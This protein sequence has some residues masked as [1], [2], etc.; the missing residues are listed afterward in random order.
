ME[1]WGAEARF[2]VSPC[3]VS[4]HVSVSRQSPCPLVSLSPCPLVPLSPHIPARGLPPY[5]ELTLAYDATKEDIIEIVG[6][7]RHTKDLIDQLMLK[8]SQSGG[9]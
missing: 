2:S 8:F 1:R 7:L 9:I 6:I 4:P 5:I 3:R